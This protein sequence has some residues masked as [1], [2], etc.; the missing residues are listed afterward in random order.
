M[1]GLFCVCTKK[2]TKNC[3]HF[4]ECFGGLL[5]SAGLIHEHKEIPGNSNLYSTTLIILYYFETVIR[6]RVLVN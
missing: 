4:R 6:F 3:K 1:G 2:I 5:T